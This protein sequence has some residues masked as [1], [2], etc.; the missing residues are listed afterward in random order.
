MVGQRYDGVKE[1][2]DE[3]VIFRQFVKTAPPPDQVLVKYLSI[4]RDLEKN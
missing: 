2:V 3:Y 4:L 1:H